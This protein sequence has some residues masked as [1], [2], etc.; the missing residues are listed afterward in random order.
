ML[1]QNLKFDE[2]WITE[3]SI[4]SSCES[5]GFP[6]PAESSQAKSPQRIYIFSLIGVDL[7]I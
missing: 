5:I 1:S 2:A 6:L 7:A 3:T 4:S